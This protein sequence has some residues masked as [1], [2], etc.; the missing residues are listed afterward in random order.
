M[1]QRQRH[2]KCEGRFL[3]LR[4][5]L[6]EALELVEDGRDKAQPYSLSDIERIY[7][8]IKDDFRFVDQRDNYFDRH[9]LDARPQP[10]MEPISLIPL[11]AKDIYVE[12][13]LVAEYLRINAPNLQP[14]ARSFFGTFSDKD[15]V[16]NILPLTKRF[17]PKG[18]LFKT[19]FGVGNLEGEAVVSDSPFNIELWQK[20]KQDTRT[21]YEHA[22]TVGFW[23]GDDIKGSHNVVYVDQIQEARRTAGRPNKNLGVTAMGYLTELSK[24]LKLEELRI[25]T[26]RSHPMFFE[27]PE[28][29]AQKVGELEELY[30][31]TAQRSGFREG[32][33]YYSSRSY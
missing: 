8:L 11:L 31:R 27:H 21:E 32:K 12:S 13:P 6:E 15:V 26:A 33:N 16:T 18:Y 25:C 2:I 9:G 14:D 17:A 23:L 1:A 10:A 3:E 28:R 20:V 19:N 30:D 7:D 5:T 29:L 4:Q 24:L 22:L